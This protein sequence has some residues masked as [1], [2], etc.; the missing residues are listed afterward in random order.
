MDVDKDVLINKLK[1]TLENIVIVMEDCFKEME[2]VLNTNPS[3]VNHQ[4]Q[5]QN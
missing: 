5:K 4:V 3:N 1:E 2:D